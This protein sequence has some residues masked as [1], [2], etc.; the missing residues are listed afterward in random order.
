MPEAPIDEHR[1]TFLS[2]NEIRSAR[3]INVPA[4]PT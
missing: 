3:K 1:E 2:E 4:P